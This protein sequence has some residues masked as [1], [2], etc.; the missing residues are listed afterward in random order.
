MQSTPSGSEGGSHGSVLRRR[1]YSGY[2]AP[3]LC[4]ADR[5]QGSFGD[6]A[7]TPQRRMGAGAHMAPVERRRAQTLASK[8]A[9]VREEELQLAEQ[10]H[11]LAN[12]E[13]P[14]LVSSEPALTTSF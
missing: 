10:Q 3:P 1:I 7:S 13:R 2:D 9:C 6:N 8:L 12:E 14:T 4:D 11:A 5:W